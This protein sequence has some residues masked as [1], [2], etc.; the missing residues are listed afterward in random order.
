MPSKRNRVSLSPCYPPFSDL[1]SLRV[2]ME[3]QLVDRLWLASGRHPHLG[4]YHL[5]TPHRKLTAFSSSSPLS[6]SHTIANW[7]THHP[8]VHVISPKHSLCVLLRPKDTANPNNP[9]WSPLILVH[10]VKAC[11][12]KN[13]IITLVQSGRMSS[14]TRL[15]LGRLH[16]EI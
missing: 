1:R 14:T 13:Q 7:P 11:H 3:A 5:Q 15:Q 9:G 4:D 6:P 12:S 2:L 10:R 16:A 8:C